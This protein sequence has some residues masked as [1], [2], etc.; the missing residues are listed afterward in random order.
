MAVPENILDGIRQLRPLPVTVQRLSAALGRED[1]SPGKIA[2]IIEYDG[3][4]AANILRAANSP[5][6]AGVY[7]ITHIRDAVVRLGT[8]ALLN[9]VLGEHLKSVMIPAPFYDLTE[10]DLWLHGAA[11]SLA[12]QAMTRV[13]PSGTIPQVATIA[14]LIH[15]IGK[16]IMV[17]YLKADV[18]AVFSL[19]SE[20]NLTF[21]EA[22]RELFGCDHAEVGAA[23]GRKWGF[24]DVITRAME[25]H[26]RVPVP[27]PEPILDAVMLANLAAKSAGIGLGHAG[28]NLKIDY[29]GSMERLSLTIAGFERACA[30]TAIWVTEL[31]T[32]NGTSTASPLSA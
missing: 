11:A 16:L 23:V 32:S 20:K 13:T 9:M 12:V 5:V 21:V 29:S 1:V 18:A 25:L 28:F 19:C 6:Y 15:D 31:K 30:Q 24:P 17:R 4:V 10:N 8:T 27:D 14:A 3:A 22:E 2:D 7:Q 26:H